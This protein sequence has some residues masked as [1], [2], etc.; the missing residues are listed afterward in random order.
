MT[1]K[2]KREVVESMKHYSS[3]HI[4][5]ETGIP[6]KEVYHILEQ[7]EEKKNRRQKEMRNVA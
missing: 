2:R 6:Q 7:L 3:Y 5:L 1:N 4:A